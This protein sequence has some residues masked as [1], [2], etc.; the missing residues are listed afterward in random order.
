M[1]WTNSQCTWITESDI[2]HVLKNI[3]RETQAQGVSRFNKYFLITIKPD[4]NW[5]YVNDQLLVKLKFDKK[6]VQLSC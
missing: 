2:Y 3:T 4:H 5:M 6:R 1:G